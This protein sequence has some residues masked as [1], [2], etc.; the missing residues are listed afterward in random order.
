[1]IDS[2]KQLQAI[3][4]SACCTCQ[5]CTAPRVWV[6][7]QPQRLD[8]KRVKQKYTAT[9]VNILKTLR[10]LMPHHW[11]ACLHHRSGHELD[12]STLANLF[13]PLT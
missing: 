12:L 3:S 9:S 1:M 5:L 7:L 13:S 11:N 8:D 2:N 6:T 10:A 4:Q